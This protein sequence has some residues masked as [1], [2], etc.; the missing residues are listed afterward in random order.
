VAQTGCDFS[1]WTNSDIFVNTRKFPQVSGIFPLS[2]DAGRRRRLIFTAR[3]RRHSESLSWN[4]DQNVGNSSD[5]SKG[6]F[7]T[8]MSKFD[9]SQVSQPVT[10]PE[11]VDTFSL[12]LPHLIGFSCVCPKSPDCRK[13]QPGREFIESLQPKPQK[14][15][16]HGD[17]WRRLVPTQSPSHGRPT[18]KKSSPP[19]KE[20][21]KC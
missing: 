14:F 12:K 7:Q 16:F 18:P 2:G 3:S 19:S 8:G 5:I 21:T 15:P 17:D 9:P 10:Q 1:V 4:S 20:G 6:L 11:R 13:R